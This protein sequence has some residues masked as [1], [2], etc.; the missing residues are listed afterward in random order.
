MIDNEGKNLGVLTKE[1]ALELAREKGLD[2]L[3][4][5]PSAQPPI[6]KIMDM[7]KYLYQEQKKA[8]EG[9]KGQRS[10]TKEVRFSVRT[11]GGDLEFKAAQVDKFLQ[12][13]YKMRILMTLKGRE[14]ALRDFA[15]TRLKNFLSLIKE[16]YKIEQEPKSTPRGIM[17]TII[18]S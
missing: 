18:K 2:L 13:R 17:M 12:K 6:A 15:N 9:R 11:S 14:K 4:I 3:E 8:R 5:V 10:E 7:G 1:A 16:S